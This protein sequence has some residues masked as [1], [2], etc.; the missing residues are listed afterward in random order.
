MYSSNPAET[1]VKTTVRPAGEESTEE[2]RV[3]QVEDESICIESD[4]REQGE[5]ET[6]SEPDEE[7]EEE[8]VPKQIEEDSVLDDASSICDPQENPQSTEMLE[9]HL[10]PEPTGQEEETVPEPQPPDRPVPVVRRYGRDRRPPQRYGHS[11]M[12]MTT[13]P[14]W[15]LRA[16][17]LRKMSTEVAEMT[18]EVSRAII[19]LVVGQY[20][21]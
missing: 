21:K 8:T 11:V 7:M 1:A 9:P 5:E 14:D 19:A 15:A 13:Q 20:D 4:G 2:E 6:G 16:N 10:I 17:Y 18:P 3:S 12:S